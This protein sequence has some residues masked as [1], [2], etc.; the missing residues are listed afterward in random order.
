MR[1]KTVLLVD[2]EQ[3]ILDSLEIVLEKKLDIFKAQNGRE[4]INILRKKIID[5]ILL[6]INM[7]YMNGL[8]FLKIIRAEGDKTPVIIT[9]GKSCQEYAEKCADLGVSGY[10]TKPYKPGQLRD[11]INDLIDTMDA[12]TPRIDILQKDLHPKIVR[13]LSY[14]HREYSAEIDRDYLL[15]QLDISSDHLTRLFK[16]YLGT[17]F[18]YYVS[19]YRVEQAK[20]DLYDQALSLDDVAKKTG[21]NNSLHLCRNFLKITTISPTH[22]RNQIGRKTG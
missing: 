20:L 10:L 14:I 1:K 8:E 19:W 11:R 3:K 17:T 15:E 4:G 12:S 22:F 6:D 9:T 13:A 18:S 7:P 16:R 5:C 2:D 21:F